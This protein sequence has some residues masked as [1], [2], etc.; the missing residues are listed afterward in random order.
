MKPFKEWEDGTY[1]YRQWDKDGRIVDKSLKAAIVADSFGKMTLSIQLDRQVVAP[2]TQVTA[3]AEVRDG[4]DELVASIDGV[5]Y[6]VPI[7]RQADNWQAK[8]L[9]V[10]FVQGRAVAQF[11]IS[12]PGIYTIALD[13]VYPSPKS[14]LASP[15]ILIVEDT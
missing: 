10:L 3:N 6:Y 15:P 14:K 2:G 11:A 4:S 9:K 12:E 7:V 8:L 5:D 13:K 1:Y